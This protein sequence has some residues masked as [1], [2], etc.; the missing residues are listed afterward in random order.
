M[1]L[2]ST[3]N[4]TFSRR[5]RIALFEKSVTVDEIDTPKEARATAEYRA[6]NPYGRI[7]TLVDGSR[8]LYESSAILEYLEA[9]YPE[10]PLVPSDAAGRARAVMHL[11]ICDVEFTP[12]A[13]A[14]QRPKRLLPEES[15]DRS[16]F[17]RSSAAI[18]RHYEIL[19]RDLEDRE[20]LVGDRF[21]WADLAYLPFLHFHDLLDVELPP[22]IAGWWNRLAERPSALATVPDA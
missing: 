7:P 17:A 11:K 14:I 3:K 5:I 4:S 1:Q 16:A 22:N 10:P 19:E 15:W 6:L 20:Y 13:V 8:T 9:R 2:Y 18:A 21:S 12:H